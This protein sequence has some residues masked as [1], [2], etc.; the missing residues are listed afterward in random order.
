M[1]NSSWP[2]RRERVKKQ[3]RKDWLG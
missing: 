3:S 2:G 1:R